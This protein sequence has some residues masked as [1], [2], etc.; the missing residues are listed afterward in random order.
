MPAQTKRD[1]QRVPNAYLWNALNFE[2]I[3]AN[4]G[5][6]TSVSASTINAAGIIP[7]PFSCKIAKVAIAFTAVSGAASATVNIAYGLGSGSLL[8]GALIYTPIVGDDSFNGPPP[9]GMG[10]PST[11]CYAVN[12]QAV[13]VTPT[14]G[15]AGDITFNTTNF[16]N[17]TTGSGGIA[18]FGQATPTLAGIANCDV[19]Y[20]TG[21]ATGGS[22]LSG[23]CGFLSVRFNTSAATTLSGVTISLGLEPVT[24]SENWAAPYFLNGYPIPGILGA[25]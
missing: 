14:S 5:V 6:G 3:C 21:N 18:V 4:A 17:S 9:G 24:L 10:A 16:P 8:S 11:A 25:F 23:F 15:T 1:W 7:L 19:V 20:P 13:M 22:V 12:N 2:T